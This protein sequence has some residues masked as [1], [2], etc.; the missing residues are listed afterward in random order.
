MQRFLLYL[1][2]ILGQRLW[3]VL[4][5]HLRM[6]LWYPFQPKSVRLFG[7]KFQTINNYKSFLILF[8]QIFVDQ[9]YGVATDFSKRTIFDVGANIGLSSLYFQQKYHEPNI[10]AFEAHPEYAQIA[11]KN[12][13]IPVHAVALTKAGEGTVKFVVDEHPER[14]HVARSNSDEEQDQKTIDVPSKK[15]SSYVEQVDQVDL[16]KIDIE[17]GEGEV[18]DD[19]CSSG[20]IGKVKNIVFEFHQG[21]C[22]YPLSSV[23]KML[24]DAGFDAVFSA[25]NRLP[26]KRREQVFLIFA[27]QR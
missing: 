7:K 16:L 13:E 14:S 27:Y 23:L 18:I 9:I 11:Q 22:P 3:W 21:Q 12:L 17:G 25:T 10:V 24:E 8:E 5:N 15:L 20:V 6:Y 1:H 2:R 4:P 26:F 19:L